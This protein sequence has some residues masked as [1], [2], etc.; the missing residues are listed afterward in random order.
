M[1]QRGR[2]SSAA[3][4][5]ASSNVVEIVPRPEPPTELT[6]DQAEEWLAIVNRMP[7]DWVPRE[8]HGMLAQYCR[9]VV[10]SRR[11]GQMIETL[12]AEVAEGGA[13]AIL[14]ATKA[15]DRLFKMQEREGRAISSLATKMRLSQQ[16]TYD[17]S[18]KKPAV[19]RKPWE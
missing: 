12:E 2:T 15:F 18:K 14:E 3:L 9:H 17:K 16:S 13:E 10:A 11:I 7:A 8:T 4:A 5:V 6:R 19:A 1:G